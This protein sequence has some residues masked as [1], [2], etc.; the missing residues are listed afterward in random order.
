MIF[1]LEDGRLEVGA[2][3]AVLLDDAEL[4]LERGE[5][6]SLVG[7]NGTG[8]TTLIEALAGE[9]P[10][11]GGRL[12][13][14]HN[15]KV[16]YLSQ[17]AEE[18][19]GGRRAARSLEACAK[20]TGLPPNQ[21]RALLGRFLFSGEEAEKPLDGLSGG[22]RR[23]LSLAILVAVGRQRADPRRAHQ[24]PRPRVARGARGR[25]AVL[26]GL[27]AARHPRPRAARRGRHAHGR[28]RGLP[29]RSYVGG[30]A[31]YAR[32]REE[33][34][35]P[36]AVAGVGRRRAAGAANGAAARQ[37]AAPAKA[38][39]DAPRPRARRRTALREQERLERAV[40]PVHPLPRTWFGWSCWRTPC[41]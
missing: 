38:R 6:V 7:P 18:L 4:W 11:D 39:P 33:R 1:E 16:G 8:K 41:P 17:H 28:G 19:E 27:A 12:R 35:A 5:H 13:S 23:R 2:A 29:L 9:R 22:E 14:G 10:L 25:A 34:K 32:V 3:A 21:A 36:A 37:G 30:W 15:V 26:P 40:V 31:E 24:P 20:R